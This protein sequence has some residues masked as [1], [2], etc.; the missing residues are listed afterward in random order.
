MSIDRFEYSLIAALFGFTSLSN[1]C[2]TE[3]TD[4]G[5]ASKDPVASHQTPIV[6]GTTTSAYP[7]VGALT[8]GGFTH[9]S[10]TL[11]SPTRVVTAAHCLT[12]VSPS[13]LR[14]TLGARVSKPDAVLRVVSVTPH[15]QYDRARLTNDIGYIDLAQSAPVSPMRLLPSLDSSFVGSEFVF[16]GYGVNNGF[17]QTGA[18]LKRVVKMPISQ[19]SATQ[20]AFSTAGKNTCNGDSGGPAFAQVGGQL[21]LAGVTSYGDGTCTRFGADTR[22]DVYADFLG[23]GASAADPC[24]GE[25]FEGRCAGNTVVWCERDAVRRQTCA[26]GKTCGYSQEHQWYGCLEASQDPC[27]G[28]TFKGRCNGNTVVWCEDEEVKSLACRR[29]GLDSAKGYYNCLP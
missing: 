2:T 7:A 24:E 20:F 22:T 15:P 5:I 11:I 29:C 27:Q 9:C 13:S 21:L 18:G 16:V 26:A 4:E 25:T 14:F 6:G 8:R 3:V 23:V 12:G 28:E 17:N 10:G 19:I 1:A